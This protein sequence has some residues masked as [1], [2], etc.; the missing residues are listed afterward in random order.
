M[1]SGEDFECPQYEDMIP[2]WGWQIRQVSWSD[3]YILY[4]CI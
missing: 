1:S 4:T 2:I 3:L